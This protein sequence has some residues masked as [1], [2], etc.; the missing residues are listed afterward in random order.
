MVRRSQTRPPFGLRISWD[1]SVKKMT[2]SYR[3][4]LRSLNMELSKELAP[5]PC[6]RRAKSLSLVRADMA[7]CKRQ[8][9]E[10]K[11]ERLRRAHSHHPEMSLRDFYNRIA[12]RFVD[13]TVYSLGG[14]GTA[15]TPVQLANARSSNVF[16]HTQRTR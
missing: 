8:Q 6:K 3:R 16:I 7:E 15:A 10:N 1:G 13:N 4:R 5:E 11:A 2:N 14:R 12:T 9:Q